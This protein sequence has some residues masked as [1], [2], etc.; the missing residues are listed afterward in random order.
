MRY[1]S[2]PLIHVEFVD[3]ASGAVIAYTEMPLFQLPESFG[4]GATMNVGGMPWVVQRAEP[5]HSMDFRRTGRLRLEMRM[6]GVADSNPD[7]VVYAFPTIE[8]TIPGIDPDGHVHGRM[9]LQISEDDWRQI[10]FVGFKW[11]FRIEP[12]MEQIKSIIRDNRTPRGFN[13]LHMRGSIPRPLDGVY[14]TLD[15]IIATFG[16]GTRVYDGV[17]YRGAEGMVYG[18]FAILTP[19]MLHVYGCHDTT[20]VQALCLYDVAPPGDDQ[21]QNALI[22]REVQALSDF[23]RRKKLC[24]VDWCNTRKLLAGTPDLFEFFGL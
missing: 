7:E 6:P 21:A 19:A 20:G 12:E 22:W 18:G 4:P 8:D 14:T 3:A 24:I 1:Q 10:E 23:M 15:E 2:D 9:P 17:A 5:A 16:R 13:S 11:E